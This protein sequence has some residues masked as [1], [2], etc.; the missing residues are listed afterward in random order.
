VIVARIDAAVRTHKPAV[1]V[2]TDP[3]SRQAPLDAITSAAMK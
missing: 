1:T 2:P 3:M